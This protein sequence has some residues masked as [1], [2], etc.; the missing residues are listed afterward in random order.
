[1]IR[2]WPSALSI[3]RTADPLVADHSLLVLAFPAISG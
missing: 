1:V 2:R 3:C